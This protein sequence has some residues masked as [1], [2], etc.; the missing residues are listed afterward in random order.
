MTGTVQL[1]ALLRAINVGGSRKV[2]M[3]DL[4]VL[5]SEQELTQVRTHLNSG[6][7]LFASDRPADELA[8]E[9]SAALAV[10]FG[11]EVEV[12]IRSAADLAQLVAGN[13]YPEGDPSRV[14]VGFLDSPLSSDALAATTALASPSESVTPAGIDLYLHFGDGLAASTLA[15]K[16][17]KVIRPRFATV[18]NLRTVT[19]LA[20]MLG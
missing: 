18:R 12:I 6:N 9:L 13:P 16:L 10:R 15:V 19:K 11:F 3:A 17:P 1:V 14:C 4:R 8:D 5:A 2:P 20:E 7:L